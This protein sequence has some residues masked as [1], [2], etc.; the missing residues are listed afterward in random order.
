[1]RR[2]WA[3]TAPARQN[4]ARRRFRYRAGTRLRVRALPRAGDRADAAR[5]RCRIR[6]TRS[7]QR[8]ARGGIAAGTGTARRSPARYRLLERSADLRERQRTTLLLRCP[9]LEKLALWL[10]TPP[11]SAWNGALIANE[12]VDALPV[13]LF[14]LNENEI[15]ERCVGVGENR[16]FDWRALAADATLMRDVDCVLGDARKSLPQPYRSEIC[17]MLSPWFAEVT[18][19]L[20]NG[21]AWFIDYGHR[22]ATI[23]RRH[24]AKE[25]CVV[26]IVIAFTTIR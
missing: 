1:M 9:Q 4:S 13:R 14:E 21:G 18:R 24:A 23:T 17:T 26:I 25:R 10:D 22:V 11:A 7:R 19:T 2:V 8:R 12:V 20:R 3:I 15:R 6:R 5:T 16:N